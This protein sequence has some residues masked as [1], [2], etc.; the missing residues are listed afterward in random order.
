M[1]A[2]KDCAA[3]VN[4]RRSEIGMTVRALSKKT[5]IAENALYNIFAGTRKMTASELLLLS[6]ELN[7]TFG[8][9]VVK[10]V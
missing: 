4:E 7:L 5:G 9:Y 1:L 10:A 2:T 6:M 8:D 3:V